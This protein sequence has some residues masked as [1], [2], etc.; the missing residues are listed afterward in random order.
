MS[1]LE[2]DGPTISIDTPD[3]EVDRD[4]D[5][6][7]WTST[8]CTFIC[9][10]GGEFGGQWRGVPVATLVDDVGI[11]ME[12]THLVVEAADGFRVCVAVDAALSGM[13]AL[14]DADG[15][16]DGAPRFVS[17][18]IDGTQTVKQV[19]RLEPVALGPGESPEDYEGT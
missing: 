15:R 3:G 12:T 8:E 7:G 16:L 4:L 17:P 9:L 6:F 19:A 11:P 18:R 1:V 2:T 5:A 13:L 10:S 14:A